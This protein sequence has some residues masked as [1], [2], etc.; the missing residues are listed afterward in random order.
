MRVV[1]GRASTREADRRR[2][3]DL[4]ERT[5]DTGEAAVRVW[6]PHRQIAFGRRDVRSDG[7]EEASRIARSYG[8]PPVER[9]V[10]G[11][12]VAYTGRT[13]AFAVAIPIADMRSGMTHRYRVVSEA[14]MDALDVL[15]ADVKEGEP[16]GSYCP[17]SHSIRA[18]DGGKVGGIAQRVQRDASL[19]AGCLTVVRSDVDELVEVLEPLYDALEV[20]FER[21]SVGCVFGVGGPDDLGRV[22]Q[23]LESALAAGPWTDGSTTVESVR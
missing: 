11:R 21:D 4:L 23:A 12:A 14:I 2:T 10:G 8:F 17:G 13:V 6:T 5:A 19:V 20:P 1:R 15:G 7:F 16:D 3:A 9:R 22:T 18:V